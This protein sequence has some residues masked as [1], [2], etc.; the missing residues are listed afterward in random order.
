MCV[1]SSSRVRI[2]AKYVLQQRRFRASLR[3][4][5]QTFA[6]CLKPSLFASNLRCLRYTMRLE[7]KEGMPTRVSRLEQTLN[8]PK[9]VLVVGVLAVALN[10]L[11]YFG[12]FLPRMTPLIAHINPIGTSLPEAI[13]KS[14]PV[15]GSKSDSESSSNSGP[16]V[17]S[18][19]DSESSS[20]SG[21]EVSSKSDSESSSNS[22]SEGSLASETDPPPADSP[23][24]N[25]PSGS[26]PELPPLPTA[27]EVQYQ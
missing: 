14:D 22:G 9:V 20:N 25:S 18:K 6:I 23:P 24:T 3:Y 8:K 26:P 12:L 5:P 27:P 10:V 16:E 17:S 13:S 15:D 19:S 7:T 21:P 4:L 11:L 1:I 2:S